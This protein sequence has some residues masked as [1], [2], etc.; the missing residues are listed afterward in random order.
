MRV[1]D[2]QLTDAKEVFTT[3]DEEKVNELLGEGWVLFDVTRGNLKHSFLLIR[4]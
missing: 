3:T 2:I 4:I 1:L